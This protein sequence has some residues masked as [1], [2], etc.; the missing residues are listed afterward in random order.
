MSES[1]SSIA[2]CST[3]PAPSCPWPATSNGVRCSIRSA[4][5]SATGGARSRRR[6]SAARNR[7]I[8]THLTKELEQTQIAVAYPSVPIGDADYYAALGAVNVLS[9]NMS[10]RLF[11]EIREKEGLCYSVWA[12]YQTLKDRARVI[13]YA[14]SRNQRAQRTLDVLLRELARLPA[15]V[16][17]EEVG[18]RPGRSEIVADHAAGIDRRPRL[19]AGI[20]LVLSRPRGA[21]SMKSSRPSTA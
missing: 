8:A 2:G 14:G 1:A 7:L 21:A 11:T 20:R 6:S 12:T 18:A 16:E 4:G 10:S 15:G 17:A 9:G 3:P 5:C 19:V 13:C